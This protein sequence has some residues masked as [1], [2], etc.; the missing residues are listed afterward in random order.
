MALPTV[1]VHGEILTPV[2]NVPA[3]GTVQFRIIQELRDIVDNITYSPQTFTATL[4]VNGEFTIVLP[5]TDSPD[6]LPLNWA[7]WVNVST[8]AWNPEPY[9]VQIPFAPGVTEFV[10]LLPLE[11]DP[12][13]G[14]TGGSVIIPPDADALFVHK[15]GDT[16]TGNLVINANLQVSGSAS[17]SYEGVQGDIMRLISTA[18]STGVTSGG[19][20]TPNA[21]PTKVDISATTGWIV[22]YNSTGIIGPT[23]PM[24][25]Y[26]SIPAQI[27]VTPTVGIPTGVTWYLVDTAGT[28]IQQATVPTPEQRRT[29]LVLGATAQAGGVVVVDQTLPVIQS[30]PGNQLIDLMDALGGFRMNGGRVTPN[31]VNLNMNVAA[32]TLFVRAFSQVPDYQNPHHSHINAQTPIQY[33]RITALAGSAGA[34]VN[35]LDVANYDPAGAGVVTPVGGGANRATNFR[36]W[37]FGSNNTADQIL[38]QYGQTAYNTLADAVAAIGTTSYIVNP[39][40]AGSGVLLGWISAI[41]TATNLSDPLQ[42]VFTSP[43]GK[44]ATP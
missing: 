16:M 5:A 6:V 31:G 43:A 1:T 24:I 9:Y 37:A 4:D 34:L 13:T 32:G 7:Y 3:V 42:A 11:Y 44:F 17:A 38:I 26:V 41:R 18:L 30:Q 14:I 15:T 33:R 39:T 27:G 25:T 36:I 28:L 23:N 20:F 2:T 35:A 8:N 21:D 29:H 19:E 12:C 10:D 22:D 40:A